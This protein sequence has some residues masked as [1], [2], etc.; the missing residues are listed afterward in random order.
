MASQTAGYVAPTISSPAPEAVNVETLLD[1]SSL[2]ARGIILTLLL[3]IALVV[4]GYDLV[5]LGMVAPAVSA[6][7]GLDAIGMG[8]FLTAANVGV[9]IGGVWGGLAGDRY[10][11]R[12]ILLISIALFG[13]VTLVC[14]YLND[15]ALF[16]AARFVASIGL[17]VATPNIAAY[18]V[19]I[20]SL[21]WRS[22]LTT[23][24]Y[25]AVTVGAVLCGICAA[26][27]LPVSGWQSLFVIGGVF[28]LLLLP[29]LALLLPESPRFLVQ[30]GAAG[31]RIARTLN[32]ILGEQRF[33]GQERFVD[34]PRSEMKPLPLLFSVAH[35]HALLTLALM[36]FM[37]FFATVGVQS[38]G[39]LILT[40]A[41]F[42][43]GDAV[44]IMLEQNIAGLAGALLA[45]F[46]IRRLGSRTTVLLL[47]GCGLASL[48]LFAITGSGWWVG[49]RF[50]LSGAFA[51][52][53]FGLTGSLMTLWPIAALAFP[54]EVRSTGIGSIASVG[55]I[56]TIASPAFLALMLAYYGPRGVFVA[57]TATVLVCIAALLAF[58]RHLPGVKGAGEA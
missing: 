58:K 21:R 24:A 20:L 41:G 15:A 38:M 35:R 36:S 53:G 56:G 54:T 49:Q 8:I 18:L 22:Q 50:I 7:F 44:Q 14:G 10:G 25:A 1:E 52:T 37:L 29:V 48:S 3:A 51:L 26:F 5:V 32:L 13:A 6:Q 4:D 39:T 19:E 40:S 43:F 33:N 2:S 42:S 31:A 46:I 34:A 30:S 17:G 11:R 28:P 57:L 47:L 27:L 23:F 9:A 55:R 16:I 12:K 45:A